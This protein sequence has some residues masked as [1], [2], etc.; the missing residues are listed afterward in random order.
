LTLLKEEFE[1]T[2]TLAGINDM[3]RL[4][5]RHVRPLSK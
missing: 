4:A 3:A 1:R 5:R 2:L